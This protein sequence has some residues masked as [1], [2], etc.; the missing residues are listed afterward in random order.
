M[1]PEHMERAIWSAAAGR[2]VAV[3]TETGHLA[4]S[5]GKQFEKSAPEDLVERVN[6]ANGRFRVDFFGGGTIRFIAL[7]S[8][9]GRGLALDRALVPIGISKDLLG[10]IMPSLATSPEAVLTGYY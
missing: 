8:N 10:E 1:H 6:R 4:Q 2:S 5:I 3:F 7:R 9:G